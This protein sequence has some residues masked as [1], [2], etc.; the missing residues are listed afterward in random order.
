MS[1]RANGN[2]REGVGTE[3][4]MHEGATEPHFRQG[5]YFRQP[6]LLSAITLYQPLIAGF[7]ADQTSKLAGP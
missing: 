1:K 6:A 2:N 7:T 3:V 4:E 5:C